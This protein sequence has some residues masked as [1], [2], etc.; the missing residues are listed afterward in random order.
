MS[1]V[2]PYVENDSDVEWADLRPL[3]A[4]VR[5]HRV[6]LGAVVLIVAQLAWKAQFLGHLYFR[7]DDFH[8]L[9]LAVGHPF[10]W[11]YLTFIGSGHLIVGLRVIA[12]VLVRISSTPYNWAAASV[13]SLAFVAA[14]GAGAYRLLRDLFGDRPVILVLLAVYLLTPLTLPDLGIWSSA[15]ESVPLQFATFLAIGAHLRYVRYG[16]MRHLAAAGFWLVFGMAFFEKGLVLPALLFAITA[17][18][19][20]DRRTLAAGVVRALLRYWRAWA[21][22]AV[23]AAVYLVILLESLRTSASRPG[24]PLSARGVTT[25]SSELLRDTFLPGAIGGPWKWFPVAGNSFSFAAPSPGL[26]VLSAA[27]AVAVIAA[28]VA[29]RPQAW[30]A[31]AILAGWLVIAD[32]LPVVIGRLDLT[33][34]SVLGLETRYVADAT[35]VLIVCLGLAFLPLP[36]RTPAGRAPTGRSLPLLRPET[37]RSALA[38]LFGLFVF[39][40]IWSVQAYQNDTNGSQ[41]RSYITNAGL[42]LRQVPKGTQVVQRPLP[43]NILVGTFGAYAYTSKVIGAMEKGKL[44]GQVRWLAE[45]HGTVDGLWVFGPDGRLYQAKVFG[46]TARP[47]TG[48]HCFVQ[49]DGTVRAR[50]PVPSSA[51]SGTLRL[52]YFLY[53]PNP[54]TVYVTYGG[55]DQPVT[56][57]PGLHSGYLPIRGKASRVVIRD[58]G[59]DRLCVGD[60]EAGNIG[61]AAFG[62]VIPAAPKG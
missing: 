38:A 15:M 40:S 36:D 42:A 17:A 14:A 62:Q 4:W 48:R 41:A 8:D 58:I 61:P 24:V 22:Y 37:A 35:P 11:S 10:S 23:L 5:E 13:V 9:D 3:A 25:F 29:V 18:F 56:L 47:V 39:G 33:G 60:V 30:R 32:M 21:A 2:V 26:V 49:R 19:L 1:E 34:A 31:W 55:S 43:Q 20:T 51:F 46:A 28:S 12:W 59:G 53:A 27:A 7:Q 50:F 57:R 54:V 16:R 52:G 45:P 6:L 44:A